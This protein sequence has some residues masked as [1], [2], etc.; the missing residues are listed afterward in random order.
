MLQGTDGRQPPLVS[1]YWRMLRIRCPALVERR[2]RNGAAA[3][4]FSAC[5]WRW[6]KNQ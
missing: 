5:I 1:Q 4:F 2:D 6:T 3:Y